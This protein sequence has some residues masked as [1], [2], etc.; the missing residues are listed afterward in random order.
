MSD[1]ESLES[2]R[3]VSLG[4]QADTRVYDFMHPM[5]QEVAY[6]SILVK[7]RKGLHLKVAHAIESVFPDRLHE[8][9][10]MLA[11]HYS[12]AENEEKAEE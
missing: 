9:Y 1:L 6:E 2:S 12:K 11:F 10:G 7:A 3:L 8:F 4:E 5:T